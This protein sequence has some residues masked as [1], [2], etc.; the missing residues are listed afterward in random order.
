MARVARRVVLLLDHDKLDGRAPM[1]FLDLAAVDVVVVD[2]GASAA[3]VALL[4]A[5]CR[6]VV[7][8]PL[9]PGAALDLTPTGSMANVKVP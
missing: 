6:R 9:E 8:A 1:R 7:V 2:A 3:Q 5:A 4:R